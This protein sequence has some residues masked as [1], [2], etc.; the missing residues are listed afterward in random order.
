MTHA[1]QEQR[2]R[3][4]GGFGRIPGL[5]E[6]LLRLP[7]QGDVPVDAAVAAKVAVGVENRHAAGFQHDLAPVLVQ[8][9]VLEMGKRATVGH[10]IA[11]GP[12]DVLCLRRRHEIEGPFAND[13]L[14]RVAEQIHDLVVAEGV[15]PLGIHFPEPVGCR[16]HHAAKTRLALLQCAGCRLA[17]EIVTQAA[18]K[19]GEDRGEQVAELRSLRRGLVK[20]QQEVAQFR[21]REGQRVAQVLIAG[22]SRW[23]RFAIFPRQPVNRPVHGFSFQCAQGR[24]AD[25]SVN[26]RREGRAVERRP[27]VQQY[28]TAG[29]AGVEQQALQDRDGKRVW[30]RFARHGHRQVI[31]DWNM[32]VAAQ[33]HGNAR[34]SVS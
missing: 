2:L 21:Q 26:L 18:G 13:F 29:A 24:V 3:A 32:R 12:A 1:R 14:G 16:F 7:A 8:I 10:D 25:G 22:E 23:R 30:T 9:D 6:R 20:K 5:D 33:V 28:S 17:V 11:E 4:V 27:G 31:K 19:A 34:M 15:D